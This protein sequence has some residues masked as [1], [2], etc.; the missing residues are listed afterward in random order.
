MMIFLY[1]C[2]YIFLLKDFKR[3]RSTNP[4]VLLVEYSHCGMV[5][6]LLLFLAGDV[7]PNPGPY[8]ELNGCFSLIHQNIRSIRNKLDYIKDTFIDFDI[9]SFTETHLSHD[10]S[11]QYLKLDGHDNMFRKDI[12]SHSG[13]ILTFCRSGLQ[14]R[15]LQDLEIIMPESLCIQIKDHD[16]NFVIITI[17]RPP[18]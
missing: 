3:L 4:T 13:G 2:S 6:R 1:E 7:H 18:R 5:A 14:P 15:R 8:Q 17:Y 11:D 10:I 12:S 16:K 9:L